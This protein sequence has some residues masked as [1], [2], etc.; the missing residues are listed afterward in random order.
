[1]KNGEKEFEFRNEQL[2]EEKLSR[3][4]SSHKA[5][6]MLYLHDGMKNE[7]K[8]ILYHE[9]TKEAN[10]K[11][12]DLEKCEDQL[13]NLD[14]KMEYKSRK[15]RVMSKIR[16]R[17]ESTQKRKVKKKIRNGTRNGRK[18]STME[19]KATEAAKRKK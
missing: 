9:I 4:N 10:N 15:T 16:L 1:M 17:N 12:E 14:E 2:E 7:L 18:K 8:V 3:H 19:K 13:I 11:V 5:Y 6:S